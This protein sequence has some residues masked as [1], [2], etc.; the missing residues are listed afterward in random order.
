MFEN[1]EISIAELPR[2]ADVE[3]QRLH[4]RYARQLAVPR[5]VTLATILI[6]LIVLLLVPGVV[7]LPGIV[8]WPVYLAIGGAF[9]AWP[10]IAVPRIGYAVRDR[11]VVYKAGIIIRSITAVPF[12]RIQHVETSN[13]P[14][15]RRFGTASLQLFTAGGSGGDLRISGLPAETA[16]R[17]R[18]FILG[19]IGGSVEGH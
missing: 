11:D 7:L 4:P 2:V 17:L 12:N 16:E 3:W 19:K 5:V 1:A 10:W 18:A 8:L 14:L 6:A 9:L 13:T 15:D